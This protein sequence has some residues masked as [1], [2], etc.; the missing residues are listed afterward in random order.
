MH[1]ALLENYNTL[2]IYLEFIKK[3]IYLF[4]KKVIQI[5]FTVFLHIISD[6][7]CESFTIFLHIISDLIGEI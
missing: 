4:G 2:I 5:S 6:H 7:I 1:N 3:Y